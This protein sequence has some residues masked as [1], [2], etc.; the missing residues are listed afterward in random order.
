MKLEYMPEISSRTPQWVERPDQTQAI[1]EALA[2]DG[3]DP[4]RVVI[5]GPPGSGKSELALEIAQRCGQAFPG[6]VFWLACDEL[7][8]I[9]DS[10]EVPGPRTG[11]RLVVLDGCDD[12]ALTRWLVG[13]E[14]ETV[15]VT[16]RNEI[17]PRAEI[18]E[19]VLGTMTAEQSRALLI[20]RAGTGLVLARAGLD[21]ERL[22]R[23][24]DQVAELLGYQP[25]ALVAAGAYLGTLAAVDAGAERAPLEAFLVELA[26][27]GH[28]HPA[29][30][31]G[32]AADAYMAMLVQVM[33]DRGLTEML[34]AITDGIIAGARDNGICRGVSLAIPDDREMA[35]ALRRLQRIGFLFQLDDRLVMCAVLV[36]YLVFIRTGAGTSIANL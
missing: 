30:A 16:T 24:L 29:M 7:A 12:G 17:E 5:A 18:R 15:M 32:P 9:P 20:A 28:R 13:L 21:D 33:E 31:T 35:Q 22:V 6:G 26:L 25:A 11:R 3:N 23:V 14:S 19:I 2:C 8:T 27:Q 1:R 4:P 36:D 10:L 34:V